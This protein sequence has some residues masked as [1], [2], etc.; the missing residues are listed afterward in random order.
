MNMIL[1][2]KIEKGFFY[3][4]MA[5][6]GMDNCSPMLLGLLIIY[7]CIGKYYHQLFA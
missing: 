6:F 1:S 7:S 3:F 2:L 5:I 4:L